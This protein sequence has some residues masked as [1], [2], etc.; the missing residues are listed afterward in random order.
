MC[1]IY[2]LYHFTISC[3]TMQE[4]GPR[5]TLKLISLQHGTFDSKGGEFEWVH[6]VIFSFSYLRRSAFQFLSA[7]FVICSNFSRRWIRAA[8]DSSYD[9]GKLF[10]QWSFSETLSC[11]RSL[12]LSFVIAISRTEKTSAVF[13]NWS[14]CLPPLWFMFRIFIFIFIFVFKLYSSADFA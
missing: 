4:C 10:F 11:I 14:T 6:K 12:V 2:H 5:F 9:L 1:Y 8:E 3:I 7:Y 13:V